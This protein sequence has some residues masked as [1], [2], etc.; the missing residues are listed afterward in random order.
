[1][2]TD[3]IWHWELD[4]TQTNTGHRDGPAQTMGLHRLVFVQILDAAWL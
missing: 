1:M 2:A 3:S 4:T